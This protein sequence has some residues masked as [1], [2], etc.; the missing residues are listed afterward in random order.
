MEAAGERAHL[1]APLPG[2]PGAE[3]VDEQKRRE[4]RLP[5]R[6]PVVHGAARRG[7]AVGVRERGGVRAEAGGEELA[8]GEVVD[9]RHEAQA[10]SHGYGELIKRV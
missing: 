9:E 4:P 6:G 1:A 8:A 7:P 2:G 10:G 5:R 3:A